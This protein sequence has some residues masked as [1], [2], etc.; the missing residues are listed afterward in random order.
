M[1]K[2]QIAIQYIGRCTLFICGIKISCGKVVRKKCLKE[3]P[4]LPVSSFQQSLCSRIPGHHRL[5]LVAG[6]VPLFLQGSELS[7]SLT[8]W[9]AENQSYFLHVL[10]WPAWASPT[11]LLIVWEPELPT[12]WFSQ[13]TP[14]S[15][16]LARWTQFSWLHG[17]GWKVHS[18][19]WGSLVLKCFLGNT[20]YLS[21]ALS[22]SHT[23]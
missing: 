16:V 4:W 19:A 5:L 6:R 13:Q 11:S 18:H 21:P 23:I 12:C 9:R 3:C 22:F 8:A 17:Q 15:A 2:L 20:C 14:D 10:S 1:Y 7:L